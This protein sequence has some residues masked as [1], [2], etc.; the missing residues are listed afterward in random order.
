MKE[1]EDYY[2]QD[3]INMR[4]KYSQ[5]HYLKRNIRLARVLAHYNPKFIFE[6]AGA[7]GNLAKMIL[8][9]ERVVHYIF[10]DFSP[11]AIKLA[12]ESIGNDPRVTIELLDA[13]NYKQYNKYFFDTFISTSLEHIMSDMKILESLPKDTLV[14]LSLP[15][16]YTKGH[17]R[18]FRAPC[19][20]QDRYGHLLNILEI[21]TDEITYRHGIFFYYIRKLLYRIRLMSIWKH[22]GI[23]IYGNKRKFNIIAR[24][25]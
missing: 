3:F 14:V 16:F 13:E 18:Y 6:V 4:G 22:L 25:K 1:L 19:E 5:G 24:R 15:N 11:E 8:R 17:V 20:I 2:N 12:K 23:E 9:D 7:E 10:T 21:E